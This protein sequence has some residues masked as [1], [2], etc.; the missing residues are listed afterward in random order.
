MRMENLGG[1]MSTEE[2][3]SSTRALWQSYLQSHLEASR[4]NGLK[5]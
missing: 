3:D 2:T 5:E 1:M 4:K